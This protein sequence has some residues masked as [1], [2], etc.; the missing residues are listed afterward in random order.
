MTYQRLGN[1]IAE[2]IFEWVA[3]GITDHDTEGTR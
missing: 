2:P 3:Y 1:S